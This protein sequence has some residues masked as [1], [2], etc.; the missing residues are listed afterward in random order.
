MKI[1][2]TLYSVFI[3]LKMCKTIANDVIDGNA[4]NSNC[5]KIFNYHVQILT[6]LTMLPLNFSFKFKYNL[7]LLLS[8]APSDPGSA[9]SIECILRKYNWTQSL[10]YFKMIANFLYPLIIAT[11]IVFI[12][13]GLS[14][15]NF[16][17]N[18]QKIENAR[19]LRIFHINFGEWQ[20][21]YQDY[22]YMELGFRFLS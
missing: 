7:S 21:V 2:F 5:I 22:V 11:I 20:L 1:A 6:L 10:Y 19:N 14:K 12:Y 18:W 15:T 3:A 8:V 17:K 16:F 13:L 4:S 9:F